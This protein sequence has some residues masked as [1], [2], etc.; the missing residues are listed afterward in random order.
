MRILW[1]GHNLAYPP[2]G[3]P[4]QRNYNLLKQA[5]RRH[6]VHVL[7]FDQPASRPPGVTPEHCVEALSEFCASVE[8]VPLPTD[9]F[10]I[11]RYWRALGGVLTGDPYEF[12]WLRSREMAKRLQRLAGRIQFDVVHVDTLGLAPYVSLLPS[13]GTVLNHHDIESALVQ[14]RA[15]SDPNVLWRMFWSREAAHLLSAER[16]WCPSFHVNLVV[17]NDE[18]KLL[19]PSCQKS[20]I[21]VVPNGVDIEYFTPRPDPGGTRLLFCGRLDQLAN[22]GAITFFFKS[23]WA[24][25]ADRVSTIEIDVV[26]K[27]P[28]A[29]LRELSLRDS[30]VHVP[31][32]VE[33][34]RPYFQ[35]ATMFVCPIMDGGGTRLKILDALAMG[36]PIVSTTFAASG[37]DLRDG[38]HLLLADT[39]EAMIEQIRRVLDDKALREQ[40]AQ[41][42]VNV[43]R[44]TYSWDTIG[45]SLQAAYEAAFELKER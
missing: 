1:L 14:R 8:W 33:D 21:R 4:L 38:D 41:G 10:G 40:L 26:G 2:K 18:G 16:R 34:V 29:W 43:V 11:G 20:D 28:P 17:S 37:L 25:L 42:A 9:T 6:E 22:K 3:G 12:R 27:N 39:P 24:E 13:V 45:H 44:Q 19:K 15:V 23:I 36:M 5:S 35:K 32:F 7:V 30:R 31:G